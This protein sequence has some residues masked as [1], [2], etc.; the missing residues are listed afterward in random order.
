MQRDSID[1]QIEE[2]QHTQHVFEA[3]E[4]LGGLKHVDLK[5]VPPVPT[6]S[7]AVQRKG[8]SQSVESLEG[9]AIAIWNDDVQITGQPVPQQRPPDGPSTEV[10]I[11]PGG[12]FKSVDSTGGVE[13]FPYEQPYP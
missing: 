5:R 4:E 6:V 2:T 12:L 9:P 8:H 1:L 3:L 11:A 10:E 13:T 7:L